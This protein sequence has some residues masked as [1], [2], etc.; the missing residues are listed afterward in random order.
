MRR[1]LK[2]NLGLTLL[3]LSV[4]A[5]TFFS[6]WERNRIIRTG[7]EIERIKRENN[8]LRRAHQ[9]LLAERESLSNLSRIEQIA[10]KRLG[11]VIPKPEKQRLLEEK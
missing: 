11:M 7:Y 1:L 3:G 8:L 9:E 5:L 2:S 6:L 10:E 4:L